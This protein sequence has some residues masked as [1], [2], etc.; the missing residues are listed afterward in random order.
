MAVVNDAVDKMS[1]RELSYIHAFIQNSHVWA[2]DV[3]AQVVRPWD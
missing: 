3:V 2:G 1:S